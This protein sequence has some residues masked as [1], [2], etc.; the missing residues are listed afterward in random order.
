[1]MNDDRDVITTIEQRPS[2]RDPDD[3]RRFPYLQ[4]QR[5]SVLHPMTQYQ[6]GNDFET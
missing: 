5:P 1:M 6:C 2:Q 4:L 3:G